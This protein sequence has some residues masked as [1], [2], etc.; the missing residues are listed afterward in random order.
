MLPS[1]GAHCPSGNAAPAGH[2]VKTR[3]PADVVEMYL[4]REMTTPVSSLR[5]GYATTA[6]RATTSDVL[7]NPTWRLLSP[8]VG[9]VPL[10]L[11]GAT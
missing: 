3:G 4:E 2:R 10:G 9:T 8:E 5:D 1:A 11:D 7:P 6:L